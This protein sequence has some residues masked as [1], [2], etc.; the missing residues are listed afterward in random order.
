MDPKTAIPHDFPV[1]FVYLAQSRR[2][3]SLYPPLGIGY[4]VASLKKQGFSSRVIDLTFDEDLTQIKSL[5]SNGSPSIYCLSFTTPYCQMAGRVASMIRQRDP[6]S[7]I[8]A[9]GVH[10]TIMPDDVMAM[11]GMDIVVI[12]QGDQTL[13]ELIR[14]VLSRT[15]LEDVGGIWFRKEGRVIKNPA[16]PVEWDL[17][18]LPFPARDEFPLEQ[19]FAH[20]GFRELSLIT[21]RGCPM[22]CTFC[23]P[24]IDHIFG[25]KLLFRSAKNVVDEVERIVKDFDLDSFFFADDTFTMDQRH[26][27]DI[28]R[29]LIKRKIRTFWRCA[30]TVKVKR[31]TLRLMRE[32]GCLS[33][34]FGVESGSPQILKNIKKNISVEETISA[35]RNC[36]DLGMITWAFIMVGNVGETRETVEMTKGLLRTIRSFG[37]SV[38]VVLPMPGTTLYQ[39]ACA[40]KMLASQDDLEFDYLFSKDFDNML[41]L[42]DLSR[43]EVLDLKAE[44]EQVAARSAERFR[45][46]CGLVF[47]FPTLSRFLVRIIRSPRFLKTCFVFL[48]RSITIK[49]LNIL[50][51]S[52]GRSGA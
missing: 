17:N 45:D 27:E 31:D 1:T 44:L 36:K 47:H 4:L 34:S 51:P 48:F 6:D 7:F 18:D 42:P 10:A 2:Q 38:A 40:G 24:A 13:P 15:A 52:A 35:F 9:G 21:S 14:A 26:V 32:A 25:K 33:V 19:Y 8:V 39:E 12:G 30:S 41:Q 3:T 11:D 28:C 16:R 46:F 37:A 20:K 22:Q 43:Q 50:N 23:K 29:E 49:S 5:A